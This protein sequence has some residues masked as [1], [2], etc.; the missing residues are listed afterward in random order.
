MNLNKFEKFL[1][2]FSKTDI[3]A[4]GFCTN[5]TR[6]TQLSIAIMVINTGI[7][8][9]FSSF[10]AIQSTFAGVFGT[11]SAVIIGIIYSFTIITFD[12]EIVSDTSFMDKSMGFSDKIKF[13]LKSSLRIVSAVLI[14][15]VISKP[16]ELKIMDGKIQDHLKTTIRQQQTIS[17]TDSINKQIKTARESITDAEKKVITQSKRAK[18]ENE[19][20]GGIG[21]NY[22][23]A[24]KEIT[25]AENYI[26]A[27]R[28]NIVTYESNLKEI[29]SKIDKEIDKLLTQ[30]QDILSRLVALH[31]L[32]SPKTDHITDIFEKDR[33]IK[34]GNQVNRVSWAIMLF[35]MMLELFPTF[36][37]MLMPRNE[38]MAYRDARRLLS[39]NK[40]HQ[41]H[42]VLQDK[43]ASEN[44]PENLVN[45]Y[46]EISDQMESLVE[47]NPNHRIVSVPSDETPVL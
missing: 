20:Y 36:I 38:Y 43:I 15:L 26:K 47:D 22:R 6:M 10:F 19:S 34:L 42:N 8:A 32:E 3:E 18:D 24:Q 40:I 45:L 41:Y 31:E 27:E 28:S 23:A 44:D 21:T 25:D 12:R 37:K 9:F 2:W 13:I 39:V 5:E 30:H 33:I 17:G 7:F 29:D 16:I 4:L 1:L 35:F 14:A 11:I 46:H